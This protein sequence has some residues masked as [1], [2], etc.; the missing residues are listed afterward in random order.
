L[1]S[2]WRN[3]YKARVSGAEEHFNPFGTSLQANLDAPGWIARHGLTVDAPPVGDQ[4]GPD[5]VRTAAAPLRLDFNR[6]KT[7]VEVRRTRELGGHLS[8]AVRT[9][10][11]PVLFR[12][13]LRGDPTVVEW[14]HEIIGEAIIDAEQSALAA[15]QR[16]LQ[17]AGGALQVI[18]GPAEVNRLE[19]AGLN[20]ESARRAVS[21]DL[22]TAWSHRP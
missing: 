21:G 4:E 6:L 22:D 3:G 17:A 8:S 16:A 7:S 20:K 5:T 14:A 18:S 13:Y 10:T 19:H 15:H 12:N 1:W 11:I 9:N 2:S